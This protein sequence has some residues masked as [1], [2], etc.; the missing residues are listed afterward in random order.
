[1][2]MERIGSALATKTE[3]EIAVGSSWHP[4]TSLPI[5]LSVEQRFRTNRK[6]ETGFFVGGGFVPANLVGGFKLETYGQAGIVGIN[7][8][9]H[10]FD[11]ALTIEKEIARVGKSS[12]A[13]GA[14]AWAGGQDN[15]ARLD[16]GPRA[17]FR[18]PLPNVATAK[19]S[20]D[21]RQRVM[22]SAAPD[23]GPA[24]TLSTQF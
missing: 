23:S 12:I 5:S 13:L 21:W 4:S 3:E 6:S 7:S 18:L 10:F 9:T 16:V 15:V 2:F 1:M 24:V 14:G 8:R 22:G 11:A 20:L 19:L 17:T